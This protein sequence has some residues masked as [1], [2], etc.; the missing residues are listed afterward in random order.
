[1]NESN[2]V[3]ILNET[4][5]DESKM[6]CPFLRRD[7][8]FIIA[9]ET[10]KPN[11][12]LNSI[13]YECYICSRKFNFLSNFNKHKDIH[14]QDISSIECKYCDKQFAIKSALKIHLKDNCTKISNIERR[15][16][17]IRDRIKISKSHKHIKVRSTTTMPVKRIT[18]S[19]KGA[20]PNTH[21]PSEIS[22]HEVESYRMCKV[23]SSYF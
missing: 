11:V 2:S 6:Q 1:M 17:L 19:T 18:I 23:Q 15:K 16:L 12:F 20:T 22:N 21:V 3:K 10:P 9:S 5:T 13:V 8:T 7:Y 4:L 14:N